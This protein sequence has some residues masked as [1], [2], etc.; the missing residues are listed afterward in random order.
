[1]HAISASIIVLSGSILFAAG[2]L[3]PHDDTQLFF[4]L[5]G[6]VLGLGGLWTWFRAVGETAPPRESRPA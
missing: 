5:V 6:A 3:I 1:M 4:C 2:G